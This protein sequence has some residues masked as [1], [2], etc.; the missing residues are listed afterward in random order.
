MLLQYISKSLHVHMYMCAYV[1]AIAHMHIN[2]LRY[3]KD[4]WL[5]WSIHFYI[6]AYTIV[7]L[8]DQWFIYR[9]QESLEGKL[10]KETVKY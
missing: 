6:Y 2:T 1:Y 5:L 9:D 7:V 10:W 3:L 8:F 4:I